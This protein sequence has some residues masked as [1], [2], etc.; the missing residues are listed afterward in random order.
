MSFAAALL[1]ALVACGGSQGTEPPPGDPPP[2]QDD[3]PGESSPLVGRWHGS[4]AGPIGAVADHEFRADGT[5]S[6]TGYPS[7]G[8]SA[9]W[10]L[11]RREGNTLHVRFTERRRCGPC[12]NA[13]PD[14]PA[15]DH[16]LEYV[17]SDDGNTVTWQSWT[18]SRQP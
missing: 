2:V 8:E 6:M 11:E 18:L 1:A 17:I 16:T 5:Y 4:L 12:E 10:S 3:P 13:G 7:I 14:E 15:E 9:R